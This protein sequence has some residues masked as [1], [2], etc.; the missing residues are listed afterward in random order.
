M[1][2]RGTG[3]VVVTAAAGQEGLG[4]S[5]YTVQNLSEEN[6]T[7]VGHRSDGAASEEGWQEVTSRSAKRASQKEK[8]S[9]KSWSGTERSEVGSSVGESEEVKG[10]G[11]ST[12]TTAATARKP[13]ASSNSFAN[14]DS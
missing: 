8:V 10:H 5:V 9:E 3:A 11:S 2:P 14:L 4:D 6:L 7:T 13:Y 1:G 12:A